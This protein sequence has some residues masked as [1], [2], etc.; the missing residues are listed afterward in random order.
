[1]HRLSEFECDF[2]LFFLF[3]LLSWYKLVTAFA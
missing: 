1:M 2:V 3:F